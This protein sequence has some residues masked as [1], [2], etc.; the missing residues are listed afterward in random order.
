MALITCP[1]CQAQVSSSATV[2]VRCGYPLLPS[3]ARTP[4]AAPATA[5]AASDASIA[6]RIASGVIGGGMALATF[7]VTSASDPDGAGIVIAS[8]LGIMA[9]LGVYWLTRGRFGHPLRWYV[10][11]PLAV[12][13]SLIGLVV[14][15]V[16]WAAGDPEAMG[17]AVDA[18]LSYGLLLGAAA[19]LLLYAF[20]G[21][22]PS[23][24]GPK[25]A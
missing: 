2:C 23:A 12:A 22:L 11:L 5:P 19:A 8:C 9:A 10:V 6:P 1:E 25:S 13:G 24:G 17:F 15:A 3:G 14:L 20:R 16:M 18:G 7:V 21:P 4:G